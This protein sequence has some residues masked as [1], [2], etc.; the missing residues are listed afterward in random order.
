MVGMGNPSRSAPRGSVFRA[1]LPALAVFVVALFFAV[2]SSSLASPGG[3]TCMIEPWYCGPGGGPEAPECMIEPW[4]CASEPGEPTICQN[5]L[6]RYIIVFHSWVDDPDALAREQVEKYDGELGFIYKYALKGYS[7]GYSKSAIAA[8]RQEPTV[9]YAEADGIVTGTGSGTGGECD[10]G[11]AADPTLP[12]KEDPPSEPTDE[13]TCMISEGCGAS[14][15][16]VGGAPIAV[17]S[18]SPAVSRSEPGL[19]GQGK[20]LRKGD[21]V[22]KPTSARRACG[23]AT[24]SA[25]RRCLR[26]LNRT[27]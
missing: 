12:P 27:N 4:E 18:A 10:P 5:G 17:G 23:K 11:G 19:C 6:G 24:G 14:A 21:C 20:V 15:E 13:P 26:R 8:V 9:N 22:R 1:W 7:A 3:P 2:P 16:S 25:K